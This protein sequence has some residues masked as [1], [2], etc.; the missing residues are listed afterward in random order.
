[1]VSSG[2]EGVISE[3]FVMVSSLLPRPGNLAASVACPQNCSEVSSSVETAP[4]GAPTLVPSTL[5]YT[6]T[7]NRFG[8]CVRVLEWLIWLLHSDLLTT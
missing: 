7:L 4:Q 3:Q 2:Q 1:M 8:P 5:R 6:E